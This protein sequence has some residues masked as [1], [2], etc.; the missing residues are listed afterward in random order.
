VG[1]GFVIACWLGQE[2]STVFE[3][4]AIHEMK[5]IDQTQPAAVQS[6]HENLALVQL[7][8]NFFNPSKPAF[9]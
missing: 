6:G 2:L 9:Q 8:H 5:R 4:Y 1:E 7:E 3:N